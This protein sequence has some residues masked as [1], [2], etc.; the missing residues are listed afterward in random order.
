MRTIKF[1]NLKWLITAIL[2]TAGVIF[3]THLPQEIMPDQLQEYNLDKV[4]HTVAYGIITLFFILSLRNSN[5]LITVAIL[6]FFIS[7]IAILDEVTQSFVNRQT[8]LTDWIA[9]LIG[10]AAVLFSLFFF[11]SFKKQISVDVEI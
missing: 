4:Q 2:T 5:S 9:D 6:F 1:F 11:N 10:I 7:I 3:M 8:S